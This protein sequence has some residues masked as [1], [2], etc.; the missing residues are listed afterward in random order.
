[1]SFEHADGTPYGGERASPAR[2]RV[3]AKVLEALVGMGF[4]Q[5]EA[6]AMVDHAKPHVGHEA[7]FDQAMRAALR[8][9]VLPGRVGAVREARA[10]YS[11]LAA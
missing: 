6:Q 11:P 7:T 5:R 3:L 2:S 10:E 8:E 9:A 4:K 1:M